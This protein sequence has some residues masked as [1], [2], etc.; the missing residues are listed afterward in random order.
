MFINMKTLEADVSII[1]T[2]FHEL[3][4]FIGNAETQQ[5]I[6]TRSESFK[7]Y[8]QRLSQH[9]YGSVFQVLFVNLNQPENVRI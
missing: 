5:K 7:T 6:D 9:Y 4:H 2:D 8:R 1:E 3:S